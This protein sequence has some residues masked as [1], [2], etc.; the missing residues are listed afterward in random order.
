[1]NIKTLFR[2]ALSRLF[3]FTVDGVLARFD[4]DVQRLQKLSDDHAAAADLHEEMALTFYE[5]SDEH[6]A[7]AC[8]AT[9]V[10]ERVRAL[11]D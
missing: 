8:R 5:M 2:S 10:A 4:R 11:I 3:P 7:E 1:M 9:R 6:H